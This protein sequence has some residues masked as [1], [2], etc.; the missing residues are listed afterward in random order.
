MFLK[1]GEYGKRLA[2]TRSGILDI[3]TR[4]IIVVDLLYLEV[5]KCVLRVNKSYMYVFGGWDGQ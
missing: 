4:L 1:A 5:M 3:G 2:C